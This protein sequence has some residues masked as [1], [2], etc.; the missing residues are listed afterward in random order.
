M[1][2]NSSAGE[3]PAD[4]YLQNFHTLVSFVEDT[5]GELLLPVEQRWLGAIRACSTSSQRLYIRLLSRKGG[6]FRLS[7]LQYSDIPDIA[8]ARH[9]LAS[10]DLI[11]DTPPA[12]LAELLRAYTF[13]ELRRLLEPA[14]AR[15]ATR[16]K[17]TDERLGTDRTEDHDRLAGAD[18]WLCPLGHEHLSLFSLCFFGN[19]Y[20]D[21]SE[22][23]RRD[24]G[25]V[26]YEP[27]VIEPGS[28]AFQS[29]AQ[30]ES[31]LKLYECDVL[32]ELSDQRDFEQLL[33]VEQ[34]LPER[35]ADDPHM[36]RRLDRL[37]NRLARQC[38]RLKQWNVALELYRKTQ[39]APSRE[40]QIRIL[41][42]THCTDEAVSLCAKLLADPLCEAE[43]Q[44]GVRLASK[45]TQSG[46]LVD[47][48]GEKAP[49][50][51]T[52]AGK[53]TRTP[54]FKPASSK[55]ILRQ[56]DARVERISRDFYARFGVCHEV[57]NA[58]LTGVLGLFIWDIL[59]LSVPG[60]FFNPF[61]QAPADFH[62]PEFERA[63]A[64]PLA[65]RLSELDKPGVLAT[66]VLNRFTQSYGTA[67]PLVQW[68]RLSE[69]LLQLALDRIP[70][71]HW[72]LVFNRMLLD[73]RENTTGLPDLVLFPEAGGYELIE[74][75]GPGDTLQQN[76]HRWMQFFFEHGIPSR[77]VHVSWAQ[78]VESTSAVRK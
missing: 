38:E 76:Q 58:L 29:R 25:N 40:R 39:A 61:Q 36:C 67:N 59:F 31:H 15:T 66:R 21:I 35:L 55:L 71:D 16:V 69:P 2:E 9:E 73:T 24:L 11:L 49:C 4:Y 30:I 3:L 78:A 32:L 23:V 8:S 46:A 62:E 50:K 53:P 51:L 19:P 70:T 52:A 26:R 7:R 14:L 75:K 42:A 43:H 34:A 45:L 56:N 10:G 64:G 6:A 22:F 27:Y 28:R 20:Q 68:G 1:P 13:P 17:F 60:A 77:V 54:R 41:M 37:R 57:E 12:S 44:V 33:A 74:I 5:Y 65:A 63:R 18:Q 72:R 47:V 48:P